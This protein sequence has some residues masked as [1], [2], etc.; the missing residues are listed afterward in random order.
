MPQLMEGRRDQFSKAK[1]NLLKMLEWDS[2]SLLDATLANQPEGWLQRML[3]VTDEDRE[4]VYVKTLILTAA[5]AAQL[6]AETTLGELSR[7]LKNLAGRFPDFVRAAEIVHGT[8]NIL[9]AEAAVWNPDQITQLTEEVAGSNSKESLRQQINDHVAH[10]LN[11][12]N[13]MY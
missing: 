10:S 11:Q 2:K 13:F 8:A 5:T 1:V 6:G 3:G 12:W 9:V 7:S 4:E